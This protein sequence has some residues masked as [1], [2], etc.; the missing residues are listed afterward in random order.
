MYN[1][2]EG[3]RT[4]RMI[5]GHIMSESWLTTWPYLSPPHVPMTSLANLSPQSS[6]FVLI[7]CV[8]LHWEFRQFAEPA[9]CRNFQIRDFLDPQGPVQ[10]ALVPTYMGPGQQSLARTL[11]PRCGVRS[12]PRATR[13]RTGPRTV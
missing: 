4:L 10:L 11:G 13:A 7:W 2:N 6:G 1:L 5:R 12:G 3:M 9:N 8:L